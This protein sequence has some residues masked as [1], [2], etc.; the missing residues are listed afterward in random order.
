MRFSEISRRYAFC[1]QGCLKE[2]FSIALTAGMCSRRI[3]S[4]T[5]AAATFTVARVYP[6]GLAVPRLAD[7]HGI[8]P[9]GVARFAPLGHPPAELCQKSGAPYA[10]CWISQ[11]RGGAA[12]ESFAGI[13]C[14]LADHE[15]L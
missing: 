8:D 10:R 7:V 2:S 9:R 6:C 14:E 1:G 15:R 4:T 12:F 11:P 5:Y 3:G 13:G